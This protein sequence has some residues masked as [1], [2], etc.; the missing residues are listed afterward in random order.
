MHLC[1]LKFLQLTSTLKAHLALVGTNL[2]F[3]LNY[4][5][6]K[7]FTVNKI[8]G[9]FG[10]NFYRVFVSALLFW[11]L[12][13]FKPRKEVIKKKDLIRIAY[14]ALTAI[15][16]NQMLFIKG[17]EFTSPMH[18]SLLTLL[19][20]LMITLFASWVLREKLTLLKGTG[21]FLALGGAFF[22]L[23][24]KESYGGDNLVLGDSLIILSTLAYTTYFII[25]KP[26]METYSPMMVTRMIFTF[27]LIMILP[28]C[29][30][31][32]RDF[33]LI[34]M[35]AKEWWL[36]LLICVPGTFLAYV[37]NLYG[38]KILNASL[39]GAY[40]YTQPL[41][42]GII[43]VLFMNEMMTAD[44]L[45]ATVLIFS[46]L[47]MVQKKRVKKVDNPDPATGF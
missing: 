34:S 15:A 44:K 1:T 6:I 18:A 8:A 30:T 46:G 20:P 26:L 33:S 41:F 2:F 7:F 37:F 9:P 47:Y 35:N 14:C 11:I 40:I 12:F 5:A 3:A 4:N 24:G 21:L 27:G 36:L 43:A 25:A 10:L 19:S 23:R 31:E 17:L 16:L 28:F 38:I 42:T 39:A 13:L 45:I 22:L 32:V 29:I